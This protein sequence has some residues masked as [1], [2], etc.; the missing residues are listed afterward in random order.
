MLLPKDTIKAYNAM[1]P[2]QQDTVNRVLERA[3]VWVSN[4]GR[5]GAE[6]KRLELKPMMPGSKKHVLTFE[7]GWPGDEGT[8]LSLMRCRGMFWV[9]AS[10]GIQAMNK[11]GK[12]VYGHKCFYVGIGLR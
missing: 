1:S 7:I 5:S 8:A 10:G 2:K 11:K 9:G 4:G 3:I 6:I 12:L